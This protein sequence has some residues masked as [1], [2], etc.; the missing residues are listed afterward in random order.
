MKSVYRT[1]SDSD[2]GLLPLLAQVWGVAHEDLEPAELVTELNSAM[3]DAGRAERVWLGLDEAQRGAL[4]HLL[5]SGGRM[6]AG[7]YTRIHGDIRQSGAAQ[8]AE[9][10]QQ[11]ASPAEA[12]FYRGLIAQAFEQSGTGPRPVIYVPDDL[13]DVLPTHV[14]IPAGAAQDLFPALQALPAPAELQPA[15][16]AVVDDM[17]TLLAWLQLHDA[18]L[19]DD[20]LAP[21]ARAAL[22]PHLLTP[23]EARL[24]FLFALGVAAEL[25]S[26]AQ[27]RATL[28]RDEARAWLALGRTAQLRRLA[29]HWRRSETLRDLW[30]V[31]G[32]APEGDS[33]AGYDAAQ[34]RNAILGFIADLAPV[35]DWWSP[36]ELVATVREAD[37][38]FQRPGGD[39]DSWYIRDARGEYLRGFGSWEQVEGALIAWVI[40]GPL[41]WLGMVDLAP[42]AARLTAWGRA[43]LELGAWP[44]LVEARDE[45]EVGLDGS[46]RVPRR[47]SRLDRFQIARFTSWGQAGDPYVFH[48]DGVGIDQA[49]RQGITAGH[50]QAFLQRVSGERPLPPGVARLLQNWLQGPVAQVTLERQVILRADSAEALREIYET[51]A[52]RRYLGAQ[53]GPR[54]VVVRAGQW[55]ELRRAL[56]EAGIQVDL[57]RLE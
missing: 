23:G 57:R 9:F 6:P 20:E 45:I 1:L 53:L 46:L 30:Q 17:T 25:V 7:M 42:G 16:S 19:Q 34:A 55:Q 54:A 18:L 29:Q 27:G 4:Q 14:A 5:A 38:D 24:D 36:Q 2:R 31:P 13:I 35:D 41:H 51:P 44:E 11:P 48:L 33:M 52:L 22:M 39:Y 47:F 10:A 21:P 40:Q 37:A 50:I 56:G 49:E 3:R 8:L 26:V 43:F 28:G 32:L 15:D 12:L